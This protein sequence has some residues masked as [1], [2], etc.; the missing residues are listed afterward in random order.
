MVS[1]CTGQIE[2]SVDSAVSY[3]TSR[4][5]NAP[6]GLHRCWCGEKKYIHPHPHTYSNEQTKIILCGHISRFAAKLTTQYI[7]IGVLGKLGSKQSVARTNKNSGS[8]IP[9]FNIIKRNINIDFFVFIQNLLLKIHPL[10]AT[11][12]IAEGGGVL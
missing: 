4:S 3:H 1:N 6:G 12:G 5:M 9:T 11:C 10:D 7:Y 2:S 8:V